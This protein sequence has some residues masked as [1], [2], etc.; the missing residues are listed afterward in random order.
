M[1]RIIPISSG[2]GGVGKTSFAVNLALCLSRYGKTVLMDLDTGTSSI[3]NVIHAPIRKDLYHFFKK[4][5]P[6]QECITPLPASLDL[7]G[8][9]S[10]FGFIA[11][12]SHMISTITNL[13]QAKRDR[14]IDGINALRAD[15]VVLD[16]KAG[17]DPAVLDFLPQS[18]TGILVFTPNHPAATLAASEIAKAI[19]FRKFR[20]VFHPASPIYERFGKQRLNPDAVNQMIDRVEDVYE[21]GFANIDAF[22]EFLRRRLPDHP[23]VRILYK[24]V[25]SFQVYYMLN[26]FNGV[27]SSFHTAV[28]PFVENISQ[29][30]S[31]RLDIHNLG[32]VVDSQK[33]HQA[34]VRGI[35]FVLAQTYRAAKPRP[36]KK[37]SIESR[38]EALYEM[39]GLIQREKPARKAVKITRAAVHNALEGQ[40]HAIRSLYEAKAEESEMENFE[41]ILSCVRYIF[42]HKRISA[43]GDVRILKKGELVPLVLGG[44]P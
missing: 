5:E 35:P 26:R 3:R 31:A 34:N 39:T 19:L 13:D 18:N 29:H 16:L 11:A 15:Y 30:V 1:K 21:G 25:D 33:Y 20:E 6:L 38:L 2:K 28:K 44:K 10:K 40:L 7:E 4:D 41:Y 23:F 14:L 32:W 43:F 36:K 9:F 8:K 17:A 42:H 37:T 12:P 22:L 27:E 24:M